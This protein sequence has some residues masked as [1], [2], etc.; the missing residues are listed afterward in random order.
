MQTHQAER[1]A[2]ARLLASGI[3]TRASN[4][5]KMTVYLCHK[6]FEGEAGLIKEYHVA[7]E[8]LGRSGDFDPK[9][10]SIVR[11]ELHRLRRRL[12]EYYEAHPDEPIRISIPE[13]SYSPE[14]QPAA[15]AALLEDAVTAAAVTSHE[16]WGAG[17]LAAA[18]LSFAAGSVGLSRAF[19]L[20][21]PSSATSMLEIPSVI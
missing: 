17:R 3:F 2:L 20:T 6:H 15:K 11:V 7:T 10:D 8:A 19:A 14:F 13:K 18:A 9:K 21:T 1:E 4:L 16:P 12:R 5:E